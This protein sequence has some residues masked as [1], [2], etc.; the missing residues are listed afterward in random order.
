MAGWPAPALAPL[1][2]LCTVL[3]LL[4]PM[5]TLFCAHEPHLSAPVLTGL[6]V[7]MLTWVLE[8]PCCRTLPCGSLTGRGGHSPLGR[9]SGEWCLALHLASGSS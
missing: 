2:R 5:S 8:E 7:V 4:T 6:Q 3:A 1:P 9:L